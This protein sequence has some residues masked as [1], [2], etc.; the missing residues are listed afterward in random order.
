MSLESTREVMMSYWQSGHADTSMMA[1][2][3]VFTVMGTGQ[4]FR[5]PEAVQGMLNYFYHIAFDADAETHNTVLADGQA[6]VE[7]WFIGKHIGEFAGIPATGKDVRVP[8][9]VSYD[10]END[11]LTRGRIYFETDA[12][13][14][15]LGV[16]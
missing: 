10:V 1:P 14:R 4:E 5:G 8:L 12:L 11:K 9:C 2:D 16:A 13:R 15:Q 7:G 6:V 3:V